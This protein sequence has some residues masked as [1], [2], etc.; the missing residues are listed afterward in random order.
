MIIALMSITT[1]IM[2]TI[3][4]RALLGGMAIIVPDRAITLVILGGIGCSM[5]MILLGN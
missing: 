5:V 2:R 3:V 1:T 4:N